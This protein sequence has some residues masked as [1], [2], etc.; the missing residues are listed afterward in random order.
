MKSSGRL[1]CLR[2]H[3][4][5]LRCGPLDQAAN[6]HRGARGDGGPAVGN[7]AGVARRHDHIAVVDTD[8]LGRDLRENGV[9]ALAEFGARYEHADFALGGYVD[10]GKRIQIALA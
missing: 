9:G 10:A 8:G 3:L 4:D 1:E 7:D 2:E 5:E 6:D